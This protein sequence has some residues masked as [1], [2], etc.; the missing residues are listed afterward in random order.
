M[1]PPSIK[2]TLPFKSSIHLST[3]VGLGLPLILAEGAAIGTPHISINFNAI[4]SLG[5]LTP[6]LSKF[7]LVTFGIISFLFKIIVSGPGQNFSII[8][9]AHSGI[10]LTYLSRFLFETWI[11]NGLSCGLPLAS[12]I[13]F[14]ASS[15]NALAPSP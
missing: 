15:F 7:A 10:S 12:N 4:G 8:I 1:F 6:T 13:F 3:S 5:I 11:I 2:S 9:F 14:T